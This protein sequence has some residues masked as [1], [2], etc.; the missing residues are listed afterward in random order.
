MEEDM[1]GD[2]N[3]GNL[4]SSDVRTGPNNTEGR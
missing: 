2:L 3:E 4:I 1:L